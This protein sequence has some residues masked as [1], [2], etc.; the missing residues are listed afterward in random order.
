MKA[1]NTLQLRFLIAVLQYVDECDPWLAEYVSSSQSHE[2]QCTHIYR[3][4]NKR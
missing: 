2:Q 1:T 3:E 4:N